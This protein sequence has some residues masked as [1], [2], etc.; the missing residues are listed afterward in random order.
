MKFVWDKNLQKVF[1][2][3]K[4]VIAKCLTLSAFDS[5]LNVETILTTDLSQYGLA[6]MLS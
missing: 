3:I 6:A 1:D 2:N 4:P 5:S